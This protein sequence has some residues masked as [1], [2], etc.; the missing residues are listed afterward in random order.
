LRVQFY[1]AEMV[2]CLESCH[3][4][5][6]IHRDI[7]PD[8]FLLDKDGEPASIWAAGMTS[9]YILAHPQVIC[10]SLTSVSPPCVSALVQASGRGPH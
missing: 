7:K 9:T 4:L 2:L 5:G 1:I 3:K 8:N 6:Y 10:A